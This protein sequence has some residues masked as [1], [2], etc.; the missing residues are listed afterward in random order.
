MTDAEREDIIDYLA[1]NPTA[2]VLIPGTGGARKL[3]WK[4]EG[5]GKSGGYRVITYWAGNLLPV[6]LL[7]VNSKS[8]RADLSA[9]G[10]NTLR[11]LIPEMVRAL[12][13]G[14]GNDQ[15]E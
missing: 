7:D 12:K 2:G 3:R 5:K 15:D 14:I 8:H 10:R 4:R 13:K 9:A 6:F 11:T 1:R